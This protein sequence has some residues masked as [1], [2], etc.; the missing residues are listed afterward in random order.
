MPFDRSFLDSENER[1]GLLLCDGQLVELTNICS[2]PTEGFEVRGDEL[3]PYLPKAVATWHTHP[4]ESS[5]LS[6]GD[7]STFLN[8]PDLRHH[9]VGTDGVST[10]EVKNGKVIVAE[11]RPF[12]R[13]TG[14][15]P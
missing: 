11:T 7:Y 9:I 4:G 6:H 8:Y 5:N 14:E 12:A 15:A 1:V 2:E 13:I 3:L 10:Y